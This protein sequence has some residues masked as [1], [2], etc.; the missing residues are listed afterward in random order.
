MVRAC[1]GV[2]RRQQ[3]GVALRI[4]AV[5]ELVDRMQRAG[6]GLNQEALGA[7]PSHQAAA[8]FCPNPAWYGFAH[9]GRQYRN[10]LFVLCWVRAKQVPNGPLCQAKSVGWMLPRPRVWTEDQQ[11]ASWSSV[12]EQGCGWRRS[13]GKSWALTSEKDTVS[14][15][16]AVK[17]DWL[18]SNNCR[19]LAAVGIAFAGS[20]AKVG[21]TWAWPDSSRRSS[22]SSR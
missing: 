8:G 11:I 7:W 6:V 10:F 12:P 20:G 17:A 13:L 22:T 19:Q 14:A 18:R 9:L 5:Q 15:C 16:S 2:L 21:G 1:S 4:P 3:Q